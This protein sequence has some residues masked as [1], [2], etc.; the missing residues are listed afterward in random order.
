M[1]FVELEGAVE[2]VPVVADG[3]L[4]IAQVVHLVVGYGFER[5]GSD[6]IAC[7]RGGDLGSAVLQ[8]VV[9]AIFFSLYIVDAYVGLVGAGV[10]IEEVDGLVLCPCR[11]GVG[12]VDHLRLG[13]G[14]GQA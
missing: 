14:V 3:E 6:D 5:V 4:C 13:V 9:L 1:L 7:A 2:R 10:H 8:H 11:G 12:S